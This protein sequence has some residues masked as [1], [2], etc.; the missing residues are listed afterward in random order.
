MIFSIFINYISPCQSSALSSVIR[1]EDYAD[2][3]TGCP[4]CKGLK[5]HFNTRVDR[6]FLLEQRGTPE[7]QLLLFPFFSWPHAC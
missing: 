3:C 4:L 6:S 2:A 5:A 1:Q 7:E